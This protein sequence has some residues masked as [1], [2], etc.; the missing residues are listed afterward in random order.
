VKLKPIKTLKSIFSKWS[1]YGL[2]FVSRIVYIIIQLRRRDVNMEINVGDEN[3][4][5]LLKDERFLTS[6]HI[7]LY[8]S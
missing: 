6:L 2:R 1:K 4:Y 8:I 7:A 5:E 3:K